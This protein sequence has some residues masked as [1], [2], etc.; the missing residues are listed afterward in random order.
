[1]SLLSLSW[2]TSDDV[3]DSEDHLCSFSGRV[4]SLFL[5]TESFCYAHL[6]HVVNLTTIHIQAGGER[7]FDDLRPQVGH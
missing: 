7:T 4:E 6:L 2:S 5:D 1:M 3:I